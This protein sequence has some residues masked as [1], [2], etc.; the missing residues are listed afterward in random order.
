MA[1]ANDVGSTFSASTP[2]ALFTAS[3]VSGLGANKQEY[4]VSRDGRFL[5]NQ[6]SEEGTLAPI[7]LIL[8][9]K[10]KP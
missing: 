10:Q 7:T 6:P 1:A 9:W 8:N 4:A 3:L 2:V 5:L